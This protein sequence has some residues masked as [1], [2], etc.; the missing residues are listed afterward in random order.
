MNIRDNES[1]LYAYKM[2]D[3]LSEDTIEYGKNPSDSKVIQRIKREIRDYY[4][5][6]DILIKR[7]IEYGKWIYNDFDSRRKSFTADVTYSAEDCEEIKKELWQNGIYYNDGRDCTGLWFTTDIK[8]FPLKQ[9]GKTIIYL[10]E[11]CDI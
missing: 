5:Q 1:L 7:D 8:V 6:Q 3:R 9:C 11:K 10:F 2:I 4:K